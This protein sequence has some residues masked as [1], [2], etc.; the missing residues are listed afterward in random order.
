MADR[1][2]VAAVAVVLG[3]VAPSTRADSIA[4][5]GGIVQTGDTKLDL[6]AKCGRPTLVEDHAREA[7]SYD[8]RNGVAR[9]VYVPVDV[10]TYD[11]GRNRFVQRV[12]IA[13]GRIVAIERGSYGYADEAPWRARPQKA[14]CDPAALSEGKLTLEILAVCGE[15]TVKDEWEEEVQVVRQ[16]S[17]QFVSTDSVYRTVALW[18]YDFGPNTLVRYVRMEDGRVTRVET[19]SY[20]YGE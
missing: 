18:T 8:A 11:F 19:G 5:A 17:G 4:C 6:L 7:T 20:G 14:A 3:V 15:P 9:R 12:R 16:V 1:R 13:K 10:W 2:L